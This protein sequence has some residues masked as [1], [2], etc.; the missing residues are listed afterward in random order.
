[1]KERSQVKH[2]DRKQE[3]DVDDDEDK[4][5]QSGCSNALWMQ[6]RPFLQAELHLGDWLVLSSNTRLLDL[7]HSSTSIW[8]YFLLSWGDKVWIRGKKSQQ[9]PQYPASAPQTQVCVCAWGVKASCLHSCL[10]SGPSPCL[11]SPEARPVA[12]SGTRCTSTVE[13]GVRRIGDCYIYLWWLCCEGCV[14][15]WLRG[16]LCPPHLYPDPGSDPSLSSLFYH[17]DA[18]RPWSISI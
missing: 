16:N 6:T 15:I 11:L 5:K 1:M 14:Q 9:D 12:L 3:E 7:S 17:K 18:W 2:L 8:P 13:G 10:G 4:M